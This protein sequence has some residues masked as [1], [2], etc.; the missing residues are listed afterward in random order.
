M[1]VNLYKVLPLQNMFGRHKRSEFGYKPRF[2]DENK[3]ELR[4]R[5]K[6]IKRDMGEEVGQSKPGSQI[7]GAFTVDRQKDK[8]TEEQKKLF[9]NN[10]RLI[11]VILLLVFVAW[12]IISTDSI[13]SIFEKF[14]T[15]SNG[16]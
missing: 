3:E 8:R 7:K 9:R 13:S 15:L 4:E 10:L 6:A 12:K 14:K 5:V 11:I 2:Y 1:H 16:R